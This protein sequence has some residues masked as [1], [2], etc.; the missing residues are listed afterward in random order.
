MILLQ[1]D[2]LDKY[3]DLNA[4]RDDRS[5]VLTHMLNHGRRHGPRLEAATSLVFRGKRPCMQMRVTI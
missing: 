4:S 3:F 5:E 1:D 2:L